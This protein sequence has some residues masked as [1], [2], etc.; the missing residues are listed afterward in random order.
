M[1][2][3]WF[4]IVNIVIVCLQ[5][6]KN[7]LIWV[8]QCLSPNQSCYNHCCIACYLAIRC[9]CIL[10][11]QETSRIRI[12]IICWRI[13]R[14]STKVWRRWRRWSIGAHGK[15]AIRWYNLSSDVICNRLN[16]KLNL[17]L[18]IRHSILLL[19]LRPFDSH[20]WL[21]GILL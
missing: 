4:R 8:C 16:S 10:Y 15:T 18:R 5:V 19:H 7:V 1:I 21:I 3:W 12:W 6:I 11:H 17:Y 13:Y 20:L 2:V 9:Y 14:R